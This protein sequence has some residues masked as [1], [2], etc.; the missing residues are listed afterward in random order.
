MSFRK[1]KKFRLSKYDCDTLKNELRIKGMQSLYP[2]R[3]INSLYYDTVLCDMFNDSE[4]GLLPR[5]KV[6][7]RWY[8]DIKRA[9][10]ELKML[11][12]DCLPL[13]GIDDGR[14]LKGNSL[15]RSLKVSQHF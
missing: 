9:N 10:K 8:D 12:I 15:G 6:R 7:I 13:G 1:E 14:L 3:V 11:G 2:K 5:K 4:E